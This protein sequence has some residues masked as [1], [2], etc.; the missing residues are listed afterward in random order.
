MKNVFLQDEASFVFL[1]EQ[2]MEVLKTLTPREQQVLSLR[3][4]F[5]TGS[6][7]HWK[8]WESSFM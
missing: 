6:Q 4:G 8:K 5:M 7:E 2:L 3:L 1:H